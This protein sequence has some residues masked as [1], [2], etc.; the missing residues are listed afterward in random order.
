MTFKL[1]AIC[2]AAI[3]IASSSFVLA[4]THASKLGKVKCAVTG[5]TIASP[6]MAGGYAVYKGH[7]YF[8]CC[9]HC[10]AKFK[11]SPAKYAKPGVAYPANAPH[12]TSREMKMAPGQT[13]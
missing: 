1:G 8:F 10:L 2:A 12:P 4:D 7:T 6:S 9:S 3:V 11:A 13:M 5:E